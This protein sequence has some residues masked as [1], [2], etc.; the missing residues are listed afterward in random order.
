[1]VKDTVYTHE[2]EKAL[3]PVRVGHLFVGDMYTMNLKCSTFSTACLVDVDRGVLP[4]LSPEVHDH[5]LF[6]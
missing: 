3:L 4:L 5:L 1:M 2:I 6:G